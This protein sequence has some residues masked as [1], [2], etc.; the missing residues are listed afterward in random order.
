MATSRHFCALALALVISQVATGEVIDPSRRVVWQGN[1]GIPGG[2]PDSSVKSVSTTVAVGASAATVSSALHAAAANSVVVMPAGN[3]SWSQQIDWSGVRQGVVLR[4]AGMGKTV[5][6]WTSY[7][8]CGMN[9]RGPGFVQSSLSQEAN[10]SADGNKGDTVISVNSV[11]SWVTVGGLI[12]IDELDDPSTVAGFGTNG[13]SS[14]REIAGNGARGKGQTVRVIAKTSTTIT[15]EIPLYSDFRVSRTAQIFQPAFD[16][17]TSSPLTLCGVEGIT[18]TATFTASDGHTFKMQMADR[19]YIKDVEI[20]N[21]A[22]GCGIWTAFAYRCQFYHCYIHDSHLG[23]GGQ[24]YGIAPYHISCGFLIE[25]CIFNHLHNAMT[26]NYGSSGNVWGYNYELAGTSDSGQNPGMNTHGVHTYMNLW[27]G[28]YCEDKVLADWT[29]GSSSHNTIFR[30]RVTGQNGS[31]D[32]RTAISIEYYNRYWNVV[33][34]IIGLTGYQDKYMAYNGSPSTGSSGVE[35][36]MG[37]EININSDYSPSDNFSYTSGMFVLVHGNYDYVNRTITWEPAVADHNIPSSLYLT[38]KPA[39]FG[40]RPWPPFA[41]DNPS[42]ATVTNLPAGY[43]YV[44][45]TDPPTGPVNNPPVAKASAS[46]STAPTNT[47][48]SF[49]SAGSFD[50]EGSALSYLWNFGDGSS[51]TS[52]NPTHSFTTN[53]TFNVQL[54]VSDGVNTGS[55]NL[56]VRITLVGVNLPP[57]ANAGATPTGGAAPL[58]VNFSSAGSAD[59]DLTPIT[60]RWDFGDG[61]AISTS[62]NP[63]HTYSAAGLYTARLTVSDGTNTSAPSTVNISVA[64]GGSGLVAA[65]GFE[66][67]TGSNVADVSGNGNNGVITAATWNNSGRFGKALSFNGSSSLVT[68]NDSA[69]LDMT[70]AITLEAWVNPSST[71]TAWRDILYKATDTWFL[72]GSTPQ[73]GAP[74]FG[75]TFA[76]TNVYGTGTVPVNTWTHL[77]ATYDGATMKFY[78]NGVLANSRAQTGAIAASS[79]AL[80]IGGDS[81]PHDSGPH[82]WAG[83]IDE[84]RIYNRALTAAEVQ[85]DMN[86]PIIGTTS[87]P[88]APTNLRVVSS[89]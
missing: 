12:C 17:S 65:Y 83:L 66:E 38:S 63:S 26:V 30:C 23:G 86:T 51:S 36:R 55:T 74:D 70:S 25:N 44:L 24:G 53:G 43:R 48:I 27:E 87:R 8:E 45:G 40:D 85:T 3:Y 79:G 59:P 13:G 19:C 33:G 4:G 68:V 2:I 64:N 75:G 10:L 52:P 34:N 5:V 71:A 29:H 89:Q 56:S 61:T 16:P 6:T 62:A 58:A 67:G 1:V 35:M 39:W 88:A 46:A 32:S 42:A 84:V 21:M 50:P 69:S 15:I 81:I 11:P 37:G 60:Y 31:G 22:G 80:S 20:A 14:Y 54:N 9:M 72:M 49:S 18:F 78:V 7:V 47:P 73:A 76:S 57:T 82:F 41:S 77:A 28:N